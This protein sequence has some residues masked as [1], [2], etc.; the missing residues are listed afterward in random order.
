MSTGGFQGDPGANVD[1]EV[2]R[3]LEAESQRARFHANVHTFTDRCWDT[4]IDKVPNR[5][6]GKTEQCFVNCVERF[7][8]TSNFVVNKL[9]TMKK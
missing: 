9:G 1:P 6:D 7:M 3:F 5:M 4:C 8:D 2:Q